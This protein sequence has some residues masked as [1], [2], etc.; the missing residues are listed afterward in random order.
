[1]F[2][3]ELSLVFL[4]S[5][6]EISEYQGRDG[7]HCGITQSRLDVDILIEEVESLYWLATSKADAESI[8]V[9]RRETDGLVCRNSPELLYAVGLVL[10]SGTLS[11]AF[12]K[13]INSWINHRNGRKLRIRLPNGFEVEA[14]QLTEKEFLR[15]FESLYLKYGTHQPQKTSID[16]VLPMLSREEV[17]TQDRALEDAYIKKQEEIRSIMETEDIEEHGAKAKQE[18]EALYELHN[19]KLWQIRSRRK[20]EQ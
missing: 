11:A 1:M 10:T 17:S 12:Y 3:K 9:L 18:I 16:A 7:Y 19:A 13:L 15:I 6:D 2:G 4:P 20:K 14:T 8:P 5:P